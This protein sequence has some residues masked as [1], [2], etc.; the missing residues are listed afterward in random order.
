[1]SAQIHRLSEYHSH[2]S[3]L[4]IPEGKYDVG[5]THHEAWVYNGRQPKISMFFRILTLGEH[6]E[7]PIRAFYNVKSF[8]SGKGKRSKGAKINVGWSSDFMLDYSICFGT[9]ARKDRFNFQN[10]ESHILRANVVTVK[11]NRKQRLLP[12]GLQYSKI[13]QLLGVVET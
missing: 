6:Y 7:K 13:D 8:K 10:F 9:P 3:R 5:Y 11:K 4:L 1:M 12:E 2:D